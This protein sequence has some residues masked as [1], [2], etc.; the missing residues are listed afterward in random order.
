MGVI[1]AVPEAL[2]KKAGVKNPKLVIFGTI[3]VI[4]G[5]T[6]FIIYR[7]IKQKNAGNYTSGRNYTEM[8]EELGD[9][10]IKNSNVTLTDGEATLISQNL[11]EAMNRWGTDDQAVIDNIGRAKTRDDLY[12]I[13][14]KFGIKPYDGL[15]LADTWLSRQVAAVMK[16]L[17]GWIRAEMSGRN[18]QKVE[19]MYNKLGVPF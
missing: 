14:Q 10:N 19:E 6:A 18:L 11:F 5:V 9:L 17:S 8:G 4:L 1:M 7:K 2:L 3:T 16:N 12:L 15:G 13:I